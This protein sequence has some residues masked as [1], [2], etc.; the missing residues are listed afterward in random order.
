MKS[1]E[2]IAPPTC[3]VG[4][5]GVRRL[6][7]SSS[8]ALSRRISSVVL[9]VADRR[10]VPHVVG[11]LVRPRL[12][13]EGLPL[14]PHVVGHD[15]AGLLRGGVGRRLA[16]PLI[17][18]QRTDSAA[19]HGGAASASREQHVAGDLEL[20][21]VLGELL[22]DVQQHLALGRVRDR[23][24]VL[25]RRVGRAPHAGDAAACVLVQGGPGALDEGEGLR[26]RARRGELG[27]AVARH[28]DAEVDGAAPAGRHPGD[29]GDER[30]RRVRPGDAVEP[31]VDEVVT[32]GGDDGGVPVE[33]RVADS[34]GTGR[35]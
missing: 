27:V 10:G 14:V 24:V 30:E 5:S 12:L 20:A 7:C 4:L 22:V 8:S 15:V 34:R 3:W 23:S 16:H 6:G 35:A 17:L 21:E 31:G 18:P 11:E 19:R 28:H 26:D 32:E 29:V 33:G 13:G 25:V 2:K 9:A 1:V